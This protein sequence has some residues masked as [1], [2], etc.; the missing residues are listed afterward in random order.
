MITY[1]FKIKMK[2]FIIILGI[3][4]IS[5]SGFGSK[6]VSRDSIPNK[7]SKEL[8]GQIYSDVKFEEVK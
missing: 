6:Y 1:L 3:L 2:K 7:Q 4:L 8:T 5:I